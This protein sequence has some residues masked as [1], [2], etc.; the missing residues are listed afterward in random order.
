MNTDAHSPSR[1]GPQSPAELTRAA[2]VHA[3]LKL[4]GRQGFDGT[5]TRQIAAL[6]RANIGSIAYH[7]GGKEGLH[8]AC[9]DFI[10]E[11][12][13]DIA[14]PVLADAED[15]AEPAAGLA[16]AVERMISFFVASPEAGD[17]AQFVMRELAQPSAALDPTRALLVRDLIGG[18]SAEGTTVLLSSHD[19]AE[20]DALA[21]RIAIFAGGRMS[22]LGSLAEL[23]A[24]AGVT[25]LEGI[26]RRF[27]EGLPPS[28]PSRVA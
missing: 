11:T 23:E 10:V 2:L 15:I 25:G 26:Y 16:E 17:I 20:V 21:D 7:F 24:E 13:R 14:R 1:P 22:A 19:L 28:R 3:G 18:I 12:I 4:F 27:A 8:Q 9:A 6:A 5:T